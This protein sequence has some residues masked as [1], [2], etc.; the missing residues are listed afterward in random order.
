MYEETK[1]LLEKQ[2]NKK[3]GENYSNENSQ[4]VCMG[5]SYQAA[6]STFKKEMPNI[7]SAVL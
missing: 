6:L 3:E 4:S 1:E 2:C 7:L 5:F